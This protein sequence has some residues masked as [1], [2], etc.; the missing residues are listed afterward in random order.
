MQS[1]SKRSQF[2]IMVLVL[3]SIYL[4]FEIFF[5]FY[6][7]IG[8]DEF[9]FAHNVYAFKHHL[10]Y[11]DFPPYKTV[12]GYYILLIPMMLYQA[13]TA[14]TIIF[15]KNLFA[16]V[17][18]CIFFSVAL[19]LRKY[20]STKGILASLAVIIT[21][22]VVLT[23]STNFRVDLIGYWLG[24]IAFILLIDKRFI[25][26]GLF[27]GLGFAATQKVIWYVGASN[28]AL[29]L[30][31]ILFEKDLHSLK[32]LA[33]YNS[34]LALTIAAYI[35]LWSLIA[36]WHSVI[37][38]VFYE[39]SVMYRLDWY[40]S[41][42]SLFWQFLTLNNPPLFFLWPLSFISV[43]VTYEGDNAYKQR[44]FIIISSL[45]VFSC[46][47]P[48]KQIFPYYLQVAIPGL[49]LLYT[50][51]FCWL[52]GIY[53]RADCIKFL[54][55]P[56]LVLVFLAL[57]IIGLLSFIALFELP[58]AYLL[59]CVVPMLLGQYLLTCKIAP[60]TT[61]Q[62]IF[63]IITVVMIMVNGIFP[64]LLF[65]IKMVDIN[66]SYQRQNLVVMNKLLQ[67]QSDYVA[68]IEYVYDKTQ[69]I[70][71]MRHL[72]GPAIDFLYN[73]T[74]KL[75]EVMLTS[76]NLDPNVTLDSVIDALKNANVKFYVNNY[77]MNALPP[78]LKAYL[79]SQ[80]EHYWGSIYLYAPE[81]SEG[82]NEVHIKFSGS[83]KIKSA[84]VNN[85]VLDGKKYEINSII[86]LPAGDHTSESAS[87]Y[88]LKLIPENIILPSLE[89]SDHWEKM[90]S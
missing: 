49:F 88:R 33:R 37:Y 7:T 19:W 14:T 54:V 27:M 73:P 68:G 86:Y 78:R 31:W 57:E 9:W 22:Q 83:Y 1:R 80:Y 52:L 11:R 69:P 6:A 81:V 29:L 59:T 56:N 15:T 3:C 16:I 85:V 82:K 75:R 84:K 5:N 24:F 40:A 79:Y 62:L 53:Q 66:G 72:M 2:G 25:L 36:D 20:F 55:S 45:I 32:N 39:A 8:V 90:L 42:R 71:G 63:S 17:N 21:S 74:P 89:Q 87:A 70:A 47:V 51:F 12:L 61:R 58:S 46:L 10:P 18:A 26:A 48:Y 67:D 30:Y 50:A 65:C 4:I 28:G 23:Y 60:A 41:A 35:I 44:F 76:L 64:L 34:I 43:L 38:S 77:R 13:S